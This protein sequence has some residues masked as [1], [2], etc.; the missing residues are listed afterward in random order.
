MELSASEMAAQIGPEL[1]KK[2]TTGERT[3]WYFT[4][5]LWLPEV[6]HKVRVVILWDRWNSKEPAKVSSN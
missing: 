5:S 4:C 1:R 2:I 6:K 3:Q